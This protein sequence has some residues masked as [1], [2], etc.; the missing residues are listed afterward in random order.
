[1]IGEY[2]MELNQLRGFYEIARER[3]FTRAAD[4]LFLTQPAIS[5]QVKALEEEL[6]EQLFERT[7]KDI[8]ITPAGEILLHRIRE[9]FERLDL[10]REEIAA[11]QHELRGRLVVGTS[12]TNCTYILPEILRAFRQQHPYVEL[13]IRNRM[14][15]EIM[16]LVLNN[17]VDFGI[18]T[19]PVRHRD[20]VSETLFARSDVFICAP[21]HELAQRKL[22]RLEEVGEQPLLALERGSTSRQLLEDDFRRVG[23]VPEVAM[24][25]GGIDVIKR[26]V[27]IG[28]GVALV[29]RVAVREEVEAGRLVAVRV[30]GMA[31]RQIGLVEHRGRR[32]GPSALAFLEMVKTHIKK[33]QL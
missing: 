27:E 26:L 12:D 11:L 7:R 17:E 14:S 9:V 23:V 8:L 15:S 2:Y 22:V 31:P 28:L 33:V 24:N 5:L 32:R 18:V 19:L 4:K 13:D 30:R 10:A 3:S 1:M 29:P 25:L 6:G 16:P 20:L 21:G